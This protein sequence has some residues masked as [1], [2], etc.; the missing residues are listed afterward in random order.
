MFTKDDPIVLNRDAEKLLLKLT[1]QAGTE[2]NSR[3][4]ENSS[5]ENI[6]RFVFM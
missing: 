3:N 4:R 2:P 1:A 5:A 6:L